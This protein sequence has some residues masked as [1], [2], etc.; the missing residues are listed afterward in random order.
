MHFVNNSF[1]VHPPKAY[2]LLPLATKWAKRSTHRFLEDRNG[3]EIASDVEIDSFEL[4]MITAP[5]SGT[6]DVHVR[7]YECTAE[8]CFFS[9]GV[10][11]R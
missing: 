9:V 10:Y 5:Y 8:P 2:F 4:L 7:M 1:E 3:N 11:G 6:F